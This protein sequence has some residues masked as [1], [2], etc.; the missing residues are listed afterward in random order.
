MKH[1]FIGIRKRVAR[2]PLTMYGAILSRTRGSNGVVELVSRYAGF[3][4]LNWPVIEKDLS[5]V[6]WEAIFSWEKEDD[7]ASGS[8]LMKRPFFRDA[9]DRRCKTVKHRD[10]FDDVVNILANDE[11]G[12]RYD[13]FFADSLVV[14]PPAWKKRGGILV[15]PQTF[16][17]RQVPI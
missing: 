8:V 15:G 14:K 11:N 3:P 2:C 9:T 4:F 10:S 6:L 16:F 7:G 12:R 13:S 1:Q 5:L 17:S